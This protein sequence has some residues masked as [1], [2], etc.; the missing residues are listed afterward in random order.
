[1]QVSAKKDSLEAMLGKKDEQIQSHKKMMKGELEASL[2]KYSDLQQKYQKLNEEYM[3]N[4]IDS[5][6]E[7]ALTRQRNEFLQTKITD[8]NKQKDI[9]LAKSSDKA[10][11]QKISELK[12]Q[13]QTLKAEILGYSSKAE[14]SR[15]SFKDMQANYKKKIC[16]LEKN[17]QLLAQQA[18]FNETKISTLQ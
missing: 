11:K 18:S 16:E 14:T 7:I 5:E 13:N 9:S 6:K 15:K 8:L 4:R 1:M 3:H 2:K 12:Q 17:N 10:D